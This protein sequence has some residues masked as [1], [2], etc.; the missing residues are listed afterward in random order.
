VATFQSLQSDGSIER[1]RQEVAG[2]QL[3]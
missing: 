1:I 3:D 2:A